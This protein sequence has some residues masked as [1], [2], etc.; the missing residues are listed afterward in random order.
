[1]SYEPIPR[2]PFPWV[3]TTLVASVIMSFTAPHLCWLPL[4]I[5]FVFHED[6]RRK[7]L[8]PIG[9]RDGPTGRTWAWHEVAPLEEMEQLITKGRIT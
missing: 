9:L 4:M 6:A 3:T 7:A 2:P 8:T 5:L 1:M